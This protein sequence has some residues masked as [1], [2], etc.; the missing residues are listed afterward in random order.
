[1][2]CSGGPFAQWHEHEGSDDGPYL[3][4]VLETPSVADAW[5]AIRTTLYDDPRL[6][7]AFQRSSIVTCQG[8][9]GWDD[10]LLLYHFDRTVAVDRL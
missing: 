3:S 4:F 10:Y 6:G 7:S 8:P 5:Q 9:N 2:L 1:M